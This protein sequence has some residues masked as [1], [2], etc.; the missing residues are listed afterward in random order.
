MQIQ[1]YI[2]VV[3]QGKKKGEE[4]VDMYDTKRNMFRVRD[5]L[6][7]TYKVRRR[8]RQRKRKRNGDDQESESM[9]V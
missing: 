6:D 9:H 8:Q 4:W 5:G 2:Y 3:R 7:L 1:V